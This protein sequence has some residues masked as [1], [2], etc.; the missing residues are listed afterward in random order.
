VT[1]YLDTSSL[2]KLYVAEPGRDV[3]RGAGVAETQF[4]SFDDR[5][6]RAV[7]TAVRAMT[8]GRRG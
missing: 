1:L 8:R 6:N 5:L 4:S 7:E 3:A 2:V